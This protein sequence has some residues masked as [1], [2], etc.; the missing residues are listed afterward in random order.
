[1]AANAEVIKSFDKEIRFTTFPNAFAS[2]KAEHV[3]TWPRLIQNL[4]AP[5]KIRHSKAECELIKLATFGDVRTTKNSLRHDANML[6]VTGLVGDY[7]GEEVS[8]TEAGARLRRHGLEAFLYTSASHTPERPRWRVLAPLSAPVG[9][10]EHYDLMA[11]LNAALG[12]ILSTESFT[13]SQTY[14]FGRVENAAYESLHVAGALCVDEISIEKIGPAKR[15]RA[16]AQRETNDF[17]DALIYDSVTEETL[18][19]IRSALAH[20]ASRGWVDNGNRVKWVKLGQNL[21]GLGDAGEELFVEV[22]QLGDAPDPEDAVRARFATFQGDRSDY[23]SI[24]AAAQEEGWTNPQ[25]GK[26]DQLPPRP[27]SD[28]QFVQA[29]AFASSQKVDWHIKYIIQ[30]KG[31]VIIYGDP[32]SSKSF[33]AFDM[34]AH[35]ARG[36]PW[37]GH[38]VKQSK[39]AYIAAEGVTGF[40]NRMAAYAK[41]HAIDLEDLPVFVRGGAMDLKREFI[42]ISQQ[43]IDVGAEVVVIDTLAAVTPGSNENTSEDM[44]AA[45]DAAQR[46]I[47]ITGATVILIHH[48][49]KV[50]DIR[51]WSG[52]GAAVDNKIRIERKND[53]RTAH[54]EKQKEGKDGQAFGYKLEIIHLYDDDDGDPVTSCAIDPCDEEAP[55]TRGVKKE[56]KSTT[57]DFETSDKLGKARAYLRVIQDLVG[58][59]DAN[60]EEADVILAIQED[61]TVNPLKEPDHPRADSIKRTLLTLGDKGKIKREGRWIRLCR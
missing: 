25:A 5:K 61:E 42:E 10:P 17:D 4:G 11:G 23:R 3:W 49:N 8:V 31:L 47:E 40:G 19:D 44:G 36:L 45:I 37:R 50:G 57:G 16:S 28:A 26:K 7:D 59:G 56:R 34:V 58:L 20:L 39:V 48:T 43:V 6:R 24:F 52:V 54:V 1:M 18:S 9:A 55:N 14:Y 32:G 29:S 15:E 38:R 30:K 12:G 41:H 33:F 35:I 22:S 46:I 21:A 51:G 53:L 60:V 13:A 27:K 2:S